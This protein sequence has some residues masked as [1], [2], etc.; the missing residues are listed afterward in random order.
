[1]IGTRTEKTVKCEHWQLQWVWLTLVVLQPLRDHP[2]LCVCMCVCVHVCVHV[3]VCVCVCACVCVCVYM[4]I[5]VSVY[6]V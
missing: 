2:P 5:C 1:M 6:A 4:C 3:C